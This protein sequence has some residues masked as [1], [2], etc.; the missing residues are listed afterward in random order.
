MNFESLRSNITRDSAQRKMSAS[1]GC[2]LLQRWLHGKLIAL[3]EIYI[4]YRLYEVTIH[5][6]GAQAR[7]YFAVDAAV[8]TLDPYEFTA[9]PESDNSIDLEIRNCHPILLDEQR[10]QQLAIKAARLSLFS[11]GF[12]RL[13]NPVIAARVFHADIYVPYWIGFFGHEENLSLVVLNAV[14]QTYEGSKLR[15]LVREWLLNYD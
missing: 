5:D 8:G 13:S 1:R 4:P 12:F 15:R 9:P 6:R 10:T 11:R 3:A 14:R 7:R 2:G